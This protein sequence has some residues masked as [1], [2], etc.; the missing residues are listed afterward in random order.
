MP[1]IKRWTFCAIVLLGSAVVIISLSWIPPSKG[2][3]SMVLAEFEREIHGR[4]GGANNSSSLEFT[5]ELIRHLRVQVGKKEVNIAAA[6]SKLRSTYQDANKVNRGRHQ[7]FNRPISINQ[8]DPGSAGKS[9]EDE[10]MK[11]E[12]MVSKQQK[13]V[14]SS[15]KEILAEATAHNR[16][17]TYYTPAMGFSHDPS[18][19]YWIREI[20]VTAPPKMGIC[21]LDTMGRA[22]FSEDLLSPWTNTVS[23][24][25][26]N[27]DE[28]WYYEVLYHAHVWW[29]LCWS[30]HA[31]SPFTW[32]ICV[33]T[34]L[35]HHWKCSRTFH[36]AGQ[37]GEAYDAHNDHWM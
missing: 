22:E 5:Q 11:P 15:L 37:E 25:S 14:W 13:N 30:R 26:N 8:S 7:D 6:A 10:V 16:I 35:F 24:R 2:L 18:Q 19:V 9:I 29:C 23:F 27:A 4:L 31:M 32:L 1:P 21:I 3:K 12:I 36:T 28:R 20:L 17:P 33:Q 34:P